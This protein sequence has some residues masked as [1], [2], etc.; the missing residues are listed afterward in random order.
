M[1]RYGPVPGNGAE[2]YLAVSLIY[3]PGLL[4]GAVA[5]KMT[6]EVTDNGRKVR[7]DVIAIYQRHGN[8]LSGVYAFGGTPASTDV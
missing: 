4:A 2:R 7:R 3:G 8:F 6:I 1:I 5:I